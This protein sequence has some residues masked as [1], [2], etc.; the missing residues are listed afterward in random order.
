MKKRVYI[1]LIAGFGF[2]LFALFSYLVHKDVFTQIDFDTT[3]KLQDNLSRRFDYP[4]SLFSILGS[5]EATGAAFLL[6]YF[7]G[8]RKLHRIFI[9]LAFPLF[10][11][12]ELFGKYTIEHPGPPFMFLRYSFGFHFP[13]SYVPSGDFA[14]P[15]GHVGRTFFLAGIIGFFIFESKME[16][17]KK[18]FL[19]GALLAYCGI[20]VVSRIYL[21]EHWLSDTIGGAILG[22]STA[23]LAVVVW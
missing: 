19:W 7:L 10:H 15:S 16:S 6:I 4:F 22:L 1:F 13:S 8:L 12:F 23:I 2:F 14:Y 5:V 3:V 11:V 20:M 9:I 21:G 18:Y 17:Y